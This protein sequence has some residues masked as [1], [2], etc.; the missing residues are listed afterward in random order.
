MTEATKPDCPYCAYYEEELA[1]LREIVEELQTEYDAMGKHKGAEHL[2]F[3]A[4]GSRYLQ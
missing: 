3:L 2:F 4:P 1:E